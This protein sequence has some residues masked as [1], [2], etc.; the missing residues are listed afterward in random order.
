[1][2]R[3]YTEK[4][5]KDWQEAVAWELKGK[6]QFTERVAITYMFFVKDKRRRDID[7]MIASVNDAI[8]KAGI[9]EDD[10]WQCLA[11]S[12]ADAEINKTN[13]RA[14]IYIETLG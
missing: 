4:S 5:V 13:P 10:S 8:V 6:G 9:L 3:L 7:N 11:I 1:M 12:G 2:P 14:E